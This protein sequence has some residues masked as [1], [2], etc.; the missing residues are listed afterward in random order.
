MMALPSIGDTFGFAVSALQFRVS[1]SRAFE[2]VFNR[3]PLREAPSIFGFWPDRIFQWSNPLIEND[4][5][6]PKR[7]S[8]H[9]ARFADSVH[10][11]MPEIIA[12]GI[13]G[14]QI[15]KWR[16]DQ[17]RLRFDNT[18]AASAFR[19]LIMELQMQALK[20]GGLEFGKQCGVHRTDVAS[21]DL[22]REFPDIQA[23]QKLP[24]IADLVG[25][26]CL[27]DL[28]KSGICQTC[29]RKVSRR[30]HGR[31]ADQ[32]SKYLRHRKARRRLNRTRVKSQSAA[33]TGFGMNDKAFFSQ[34]A[35]VAQQ[36]SS[37]C[38]HLNRK[39]GNRR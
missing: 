25:R 16:Q 12:L 3:P 24:Q 26:Q 38:T 32:K 1:G 9:T 18:H 15:P 20:K 7:P 27:L 29:K 13:P 31:H 2:D 28:C 37:G 21:V 19:I 17:H 30:A 33:T 14:N 6:F 11:E 35:D 4:L 10:A 34:R 8:L 36:C 23:V 39:L 22:R 5:P